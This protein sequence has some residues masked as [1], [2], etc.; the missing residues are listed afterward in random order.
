MLCAGMRYHEIAGGSQCM[1]VL[2]SEKAP[3]TFETLRN[4]YVY[5]Q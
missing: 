1:S 3:R 4:M 5:F 2:V